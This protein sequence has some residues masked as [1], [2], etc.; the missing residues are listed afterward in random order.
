[1]KVPN[2]KKDETVKSL[3]WQR[4]TDNGAYRGPRVH[5]ILGKLYTKIEDLKSLIKSLFWERQTFLEGQTDNV[6][7]RGFVWDEKISWIIRK[8]HI[9]KQGPKWRDKRVIRFCRKL[10]QTDRPTNQPG[11]R[12][13]D[14]RVHRTHQTN[15]QKIKAWNMISTL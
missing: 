9:E 3:F 13:K 12:Q 4:Q 15:R 14:I 6:A 11:N 2:Q 8:L 1:M 5:C 7:Y 10:W